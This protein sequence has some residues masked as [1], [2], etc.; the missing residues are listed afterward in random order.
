MAAIVRSVYSAF[1][2]FQPLIILIISLGTYSLVFGHTLTASVAFPV[3][4]FLNILRNPLVQFPDVLNWVMVEGKVAAER[5][6][7]FLCEGSAVQY[8]ERGTVRGVAVDVRSADFAFEA[9]PTTILWDPDKDKTVSTTAGTT[10]LNGL[11]FSRPRRAAVSQAKFGSRQQLK[12]MRRK[13][14]QVAAQREAEKA[15][16]A[17][18]VLRDI[19][20]RIDAGSLTCVIGQVGSGK[21][22]L[23]HSVLGEMLKS[24]GSVSVSG[25][26]SYASQS[27][28]I[29]NASVKNSK[30]VM[31]SRFVC[32]PSSSP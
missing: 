4:N 16:P 12:D 9:A 28:F 3:L 26:L 20:L 24:R 8:V 10:S 1:A 7:Q 15:Q 23:L 5:I 25:S 27:A 29:L 22:A 14:A 31:L 11:H 21:S 17:R 13:A 6:S 19:D 2:E 30:I 32:C 18:S